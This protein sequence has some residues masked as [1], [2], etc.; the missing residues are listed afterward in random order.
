M[1]LQGV[2][3]PAFEEIT[4]TSQSKPLKK[5]EL[6]KW[7]NYSFTELFRSINELIVLY[8]NDFRL[9]LED[10]FKIYENCILNHSLILLIDLSLKALNQ[11]L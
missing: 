3:R 6:E 9:F 5:E 10:V 11:L 8:Y 2:L 7:L 1:V 4:Y